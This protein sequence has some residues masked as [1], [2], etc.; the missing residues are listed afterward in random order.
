MV[1]AAAYY[2][3]MAALVGFPLRELEGSRQARSLVLQGAIGEPQW[4]DLTVVSPPL[5]VNFLFLSSP[6][7]S[8]QGTKGL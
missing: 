7:E 6:F 5:L 1:R 2:P 3:Q 8:L 4:L